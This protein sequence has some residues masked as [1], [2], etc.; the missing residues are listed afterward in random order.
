MPIKKAAFLVI[1]GIIFTAC[2]GGEAVE[3]SIIIEPA[4]KGRVEINEA[5][6]GD[7]ISKG[8]VISLGSHPGQLIPKGKQVSLIAHPI[9][10]D[11]RFA[12]WEGDLS[13]TNSQESLAMD[14]SKA[15]RAVFEPDPL[16]P[17]LIQ[18][19]VERQPGGLAIF[20][21]I[22][23]WESYPPEMFQEHQGSTRT[24]VEIYDAQDDS[25][26][27][28]DTRLS[29]SNDLL[30]LRLFIREDIAPP[31]YVYVILR[32]RLLNVTYPSNKV[33]V[34]TDPPPTPPSL[35]GLGT[36][37]TDA[38]FAPG[39]WDNAGIYTFDLSLPDGGTATATMYAMNDQDNIYLAI[40]TSRPVVGYGA[41]IC[42]RFDNDNGG[43]PLE[44]GDDQICLNESGFFDMVRTDP[45]S[46]LPIIGQGVG[47]CL[48]TRF[49]GGATDGAGAI[50]EAAEFT[51]FELLHPLNS[52]DNANDFSLVPGNSVGF[53]LTIILDGQV[54]I[55]GPKGLKHYGE[56]RIAYPEDQ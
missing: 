43:E 26:L 49:S 30:K 7:P 55:V 8:L 27:Y 24:W 6:T 2:V 17:Q 31:R 19:G 37:S 23:N 25:K 52:V 1:L 48:D 33:P 41:Q 9:D 34:D 14:A 36:S 45:P 35:M 21:A 4:G 54:T 18:T 56:I 3:M 46:C 11:W 28:A 53:I 20:L 15:V 44:D 42:F 10:E 40:K 13:G 38:I 51:V 12:R 22:V 47:G 50:F 16:K 29:S 39:E 32:D 5:E